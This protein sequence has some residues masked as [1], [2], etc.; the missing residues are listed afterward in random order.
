MFDS[1]TNAFTT[2]R[3]G[4]TEYSVDGDLASTLQELDSR[5]EI[6]ASD[7]NIE[8]IVAF[9]RAATN[10]IENQNWSWLHNVEFVFETDI[11]KGVRIGP[12]WVQIIDDGFDRPPRHELGEEVEIRYQ[13]KTPTSNDAPKYKDFAREVVNRVDY[14]MFGSGYSGYRSRQ[15]YIEFSR[16]SEEVN[17]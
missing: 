6:D 13:L 14:E 15:S 12:G 1:E 7:E 3:T 17:G 16:T 8:R 4:R 2:D 9:V 5:G 10:I 11:S